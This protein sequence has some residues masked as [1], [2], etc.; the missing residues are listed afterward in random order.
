MFFKIKPHLEYHSFAQ[1][2]FD[3][4]THKNI[5]ILSLLF[6]PFCFLY[7]WWGLNDHII[8]SLHY[9]KVLTS[10]TNAATFYEL[11]AIKTH[12]GVVTCN[13]NLT[14][15]I[16]EDPCYTLNNQQKIKA[17]K[18]NQ[19]SPKYSNKI[20]YLIPEYHSESKQ[21]TKEQLKDEV[22]FAFIHINKAGGSTIKE[23]IL[24]QS[25]KNNKW[26]GAGFGTFTG[27]KHLGLPWISKEIITELKNLN[28]STLLIK[29]N[30]N[31][32]SSKIDN[33]NRRRILLLSS[34]TTS[35]LSLFNNDNID[36]YKNLNSLLKIYKENYQYYNNY[37]QH[38]I[39][40]KRNLDLLGDGLTYFKCG[41]IHH[42]GSLSQNDVDNKNCP[43]RAVWGGISLGLCQHFPGRPCIYLV[44]LRNP[45][46][47]AIS[48]YNYVCVKGA[49]DRKG[50][51]P[52]WKKKGRCPVTILQFFEMNITHPLLYTNRL[53]R[54]CD[55]NCG[56]QVA[57]KNL[58]HPC[59]RYLLLE[60]FDE[61]LNKLSKVI[62][63]G[64][65]PA[66][67]KYLNNQKKENA[68]PYSWRTIRQIRNKQIMKKLK[69]MLAQDEAIYELAVKHFD[70]QWEDDY[71]LV[72]CNG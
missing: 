37:H 36:N 20:S 28:S 35:S 25:I 18:C 44:S 6:F 22:I 54:G 15:R 39:F 65:K 10:G 72:S 66:I 70:E 16:Y 69:I 23:D 56:A 12:H 51:L 2:K 19:R 63:P 5:L 30:N 64:L 49:E 3:F 67:K 55:K 61:S 62:G 46:E 24:F 21:L 8:P 14:R 50:W 4:M 59:V 71:P 13:N 60:R 68:S 38:N 29:G 7:F 47:R 42:R 57:L 9:H 33:N 27:W 34:S 52:E 40:K 1:L 45:I 43:M 26:S 58:R 17:C 53:T 31:K 41:K 48:N 32:T 11:K